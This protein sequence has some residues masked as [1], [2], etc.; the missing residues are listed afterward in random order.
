MEQG[1]IKNH[2]KYQAGE[3]APEKLALQ[4]VPFAQGMLYIGSAAPLSDDEIALTQTLADA[5]AV[6]YA[7]YDDFQRLEAAKAEIEAALE[8]LKKTQGQL[9]QAEKMASLGQL[10]AGIAHEIKNPLNFVTNFA[11]LSSELIDELSEE[12]HA[13][14]DK[15]IAD[16]RDLLDEL[17][18]DLRA[19]NEK[20]NEH[21]K[22]ADSIVKSMMQ[23]ARGGKNERQPTEL[24]ALVEEYL[25]LTYHGMRARVA[26][27]NVSIERDFGEI[28]GKV[29]MVPQEIGR[30]LLNIMGNACDA[31]HQRAQSEGEAYQPKLSVAT[32]R[33]AAGIEI[34]IGDNGG[35]ISDEIREKIFEPFFTTKPTGS[36]TG[37]GLSLSYD[38]VTHGHGGTL[39]MESSPDEG[40]SFI[41]TLPGFSP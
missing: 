38:I 7:R 29:E 3:A 39:T 31:V 24:N 21:G 17:L 10:T 2:R 33:V 35:G 25:N 22:R 16:L 23:H 9:V 40:A 32:R 30:V 27:F 15:S 36:G 37:L 1:F 28:D 11:Q 4:F 14:P 20:I 5:F 13:N 26:N 19:N 6:A 41:I 18:T 12:L 34:R 8:N